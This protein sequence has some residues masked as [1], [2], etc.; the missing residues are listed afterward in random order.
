MNYKQALGVLAGTLTHTEALDD[1]RRANIRYAH[2][3]MSWWKNR[4]E[5]T[6]FPTPDLQAI[7]ALLG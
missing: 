1:M 4:S 3:Q 5:I 2:R 7:R 6:W